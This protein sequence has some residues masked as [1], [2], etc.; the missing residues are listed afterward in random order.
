MYREF[1][2][3]VLTYLIVSP[4]TFSVLAYIYENT[5]LS[6]LTFISYFLLA[7]VGG[8]IGTVF[9]YYAYN[10][11]KV[12]PFVLGFIP[13]FILIVVAVKMNVSDLIVMG[14]LCLILS[15]WFTAS[16]ITSVKI[17]TSKSL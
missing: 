16:D 13:T 15:C 8:S 14:D 11:I 17:K 2:I 10:A 9:G 12:N 4:L 5:A 7:L 1:R 3:K 6:V